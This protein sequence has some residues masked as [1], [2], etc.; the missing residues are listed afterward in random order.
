LDTILSN[1]FLK[2]RLL[3][4]PS[5]V[6]QQSNSKRNLNLLLKLETFLLSL[7][8]EPQRQQGHQPNRK[9]KRL[10]PSSRQK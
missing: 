8:V 4:D 1:N 2:E 7:Q 6:I 5:A 10:F 9:P 3:I